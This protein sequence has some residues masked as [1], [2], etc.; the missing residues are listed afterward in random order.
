[1]ADSFF[2]FFYLIYMM[3]YG[4]GGG[5]RAWINQFRSVDMGCWCT[6]GNRLW[7]H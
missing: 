6:V 4:G 3:M 1:M 5:A 7:L 2:L